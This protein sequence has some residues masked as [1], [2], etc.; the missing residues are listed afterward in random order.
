[1]LA[2]ADDIVKISLKITFQ[3]DIKGLVK[4]IT[5]THKKKSM[6]APRLELE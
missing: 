5:H 6:E 4:F 2:F 3:M 1:M